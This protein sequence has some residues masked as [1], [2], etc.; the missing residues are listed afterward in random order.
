MKHC[1][2]SLSCNELPFLKQKLS[3]LYKY[4]SQ[5][6]FIDYNILDKCNSTDGSIEYIE[7]FDDPYN[8]ITLL[9]DFDPKKIDKFN[10][11]SV[12]EK[13]K[14]FSYG[15]KYIKDD[16]DTIW[17]TDL[18]EFFKKKLIDKV[19]MLYT[20]DK[21]LVSINIP[22]ISFVY[23]QYN[24][25][26]YKSPLYIAPRVTKHVKGKI[27]GHCNFNTYGKTV[28]ITDHSLYHF[29]YVGYNR[30]RHKLIIFNTKSDSKH[31]EK[32]SWL[33]KYKNVLEKGD[34]YININH[35]GNKLIKSKEYDGDYLEYIDIENMI[36]ELN[37]I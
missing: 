21:S 25:F 13:Q 37:D 31:H 19:E 6:I 22:H 7:S 14:M 35:P 28:K 2:F 27:Y 12:I 34:K 5:I 20:N 26:H 4:F 36:N 23:N 30:C 9:K 3:F 33:K 8:K 29:S 18:D 32:D 24:K 17:A 16:I 1:Y 15:S 11:V 10:G